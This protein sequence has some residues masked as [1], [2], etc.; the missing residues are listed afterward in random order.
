MCAQSSADQTRAGHV[1]G[2]ARQRSEAPERQMTPA[3]SC[4]LRLLTHLAMLQGA[5]KN[6]KVGR[7]PSLGKGPGPGEGPRAWGR[8]PGLGKAPGLGESSL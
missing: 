7:A 2:G 6:R 3:Q 1:L 4:V 5:C 8:A